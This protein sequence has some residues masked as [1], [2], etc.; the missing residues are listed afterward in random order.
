MTD[1]IDRANDRA[2]QMLAEALAAQTH[3]ARSG[4][5]ATSAIDCE[6]CPEPIPEA[7]RLALPGVRRCLSCAMAQ[8][9]KQA[10]KQ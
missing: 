7:R 10:R 6:D 5:G 8:E 4:L 1:D 3:R 2:A 9:K